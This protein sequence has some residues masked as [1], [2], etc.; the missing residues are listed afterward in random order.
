VTPPGARPRRG[1]PPTSGLSFERIVEAALAMVDRD[2]LDALTVARLARELR[3]GEM[4]LYGYIRTKEEILDAL[5][6]SLIGRLSPRTFDPG[7][8]WA[9]QVVELFVEV[10]GLLAAHPEVGGLF[11]TRHVVGPGSARALEM[12]LAL[13]HAGGVT[14]EDAVAAYRVLISYTVG[15]ALYTRAHHDP[16]RELRWNSYL[17]GLPARG[18]PTLH[19]S[20]ADIAGPPDPGLFAAGLRNLLATIQTPTS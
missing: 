14:G 10:H 15:Y 13:L 5:G 20:L 6:D 3:V 2:G 8:D 7:R 12:I 11:A 17:H 16:E 19:G 18:F 9:D 4:T 1:R